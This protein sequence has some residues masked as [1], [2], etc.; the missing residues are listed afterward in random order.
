MIS[1]SLSPSC[2][3]G[4]SVSVTG[5]VLCP[6]YWEE[7]HSYSRRSW[8]SYQREMLQELGGGEEEEDDADKYDSD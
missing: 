4:G 2:G 7:E 8:Q 6:G 3:W 1:V 5:G